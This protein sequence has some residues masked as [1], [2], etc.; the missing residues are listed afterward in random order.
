MSPAGYVAIDLGAQSGRVLLGTFTPNGLN[1][2][3]I[4]RFPNTPTEVNGVLC[5][6]GAALFAAAMSG[7]A[8]IVERGVSIAGIA[9]DT[10]GVDYG[11]VGESGELVAPLRHYRA[12]NPDVMRDA[13][14]LVPT[15]EAYART[16]IEESPINTCFQLIRD[17][18]L[19]FLDQ[20]CTMLLTPDLWSFWLTGE[21]GAERTIASTTAMLDRTTGEWALDLIER[22]GIPTAI[23]PALQ[24]SGS[25]AGETQPT[26]TSQLKASEPLPVFR[27]GAHDTASAFAAV[28]DSTRPTAVISCGTWALAGC[29]STTPVLTQEGQDLGFTNEE[30]ADGRLLVMRNLSGTWLLDEC[31]RTWAEDL[32]ITDLTAFRNTLLSGLRTAEMDFG[33]VI[34]PGDPTLLQPGDMPQRIHSLYAQVT[35]RSLSSDPKDTVALILRSL[36]IAFAQA[37]Q[38][39]AHLTNQD[40]QEVVIIGGGSQ[41][42]PL[43]ELTQRAVGLPVKR[44]PV[45]ATG[46]GSV[47]VQAVAAGQ[48]DSLDDAREAAAVW[49]KA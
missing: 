41:I 2:Q 6:D 16:G 42:E 40:L 12:A 3:E 15:R 9:V 23:L 13:R 8:T 4:S 35:G 44:G 30:G 1:L 18:E 38:G 17:R 21:T 39:A 14:A 49:G 5:W 34:D 43:I 19:G 22:Y 36:A 48:F 31:L 29:L 45:E 32:S 28:V 33:D 7:L 20:P 26:I 25:F 46:L 37:I 24:P 47:L 10:W 27:T 11:L